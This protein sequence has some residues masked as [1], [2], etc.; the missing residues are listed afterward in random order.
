MQ[1]QPCAAS[2]ANINFHSLNLDEGENT[3]DMDEYLKL[4]EDLIS[5]RLAEFMEEQLWSQ[6]PP[7]VVV[8]DSG[9]P[10]AM[11]VAK[12]FGV[13]GASFFT[14]CWAVN[15]IFYHLK[16]GAFR[17]PLEDPVVS[18]PSMP[19]LGLSDLPT[20]ATDNSG[21]GAYPSLCK[22]VRS[23]FENLEEAN[24]VFCNTYDMLE[25]EKL[26]SQRLASFIHDQISSSSS[27]TPPKALVYDSFLPWAL[28]VA[29]M[30]GIHGA[31]FFTQSWSNSSIYYH[32][33][34]GTLKVPL[35]HNAV[36]SLPSMPVL[37]IH[38]L[39]SFVSDTGSY[40]HLLNMVVDRFSNFQEADSLFC[41]SFI[42]LEHEVF[43]T[44]LV[45]NAANHR[46][47][48]AHLGNDA[49]CNAFNHH[50]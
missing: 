19:A 45:V 26:V 29:K 46:Q 22:L 38:D 10:W 30:F 5:K 36:V 9:M 13:L 24:W 14:Q 16:R 28:D 32:V 7:K 49:R 37:G 23:Q 12:K 3:S 35:E 25:Q 11:G 1:M 27:S 6:N 15:A 40:P 50:L 8:Y 21:G 2:S 33:N 18:L 4:Y 42:H 31:S 44:V 48:H 17:V 47:F 43:L 20:F 41:N 34:Q 39:P